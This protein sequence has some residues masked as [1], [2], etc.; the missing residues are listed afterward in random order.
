M[1]FDVRLHGKV[2]KALPRLRGSDREKFLE[3]E[4]KLA[5]EGP[6]RKE[7]QSFSKLYKTK[8][9]HGHITNSLVAIWDYDKS[10]GLI[11]ILWLGNRENIDYARLNKRK[12]G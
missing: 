2:K 3:F 4:K 6:I 9:L 12:G 8:Y 7:L 11:T 10:R 1:S 5:E